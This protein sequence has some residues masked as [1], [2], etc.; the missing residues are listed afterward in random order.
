MGTKEKPLG[1]AIVICER[2]I[3][4]AGT[5]TKTLVAIFNQLTSLGMPC[6]QSS[7]SVYVALTSASGNRAV[8]LRMTCEEQTIFSVLGDADFVNPNTVV[9]LI[10]S[11][12]NVTFSKPGIYAFEVHVAGEY[13]FESRF[14]V[15][16][17]KE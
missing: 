7:M 14:V 3:Q 16:T 17:S 2:V 5:G 6:I 13:I 11:L 12:R 15:A 9:E 10:F 4:E 1:T 8:E